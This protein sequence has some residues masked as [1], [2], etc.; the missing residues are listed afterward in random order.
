MATAPAMRTFGAQLSSTP[1][2]KEKKPASVI[3][4]KSLI[5]PA[6]SAET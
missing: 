6:I 2:V 4:L 3:V 1:A 5:E